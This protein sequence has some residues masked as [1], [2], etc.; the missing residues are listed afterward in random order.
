[1]ILIRV[2]LT[3]PYYEIYNISESGDLTISKY[4]NNLGD[5]LNSFKKIIICVSSSL[6]VVGSREVNDIEKLSK[7]KDKF[8]FG[9]KILD[10]ED[11][12]IFSSAKFK[13]NNIKQ[14][15]MSKKEFNNKINPIIE[16]YRKKIVSISSEI[17]LVDDNKNKSNVYFSEKNLN[18]IYKK[19]QN[20]ELKIY[21]KKNN[22]LDKF[23]IKENYN[24]L[25]L[26]TS[27]KNEP[28]FEILKPSRLK[29]FLIFIALLNIII[30]VIQFNVVKTTN[31][32]DLRKSDFSINEKQTFIEI[33]NKFSDYLKQQTPDDQLLT[34]RWIEKLSEDNVLNLKELNIDFDNKLIKINY[35]D[36]YNGFRDVLFNNAINFK[37][38]KNNDLIEYHINFSEID[39]FQ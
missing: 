37:E 16:N 20:R 17:F 12:L 25:K 22:L 38:I 28:K 30:F 18:H 9:N 8:F 33:S 39:K 27:Y 29:N 6:C 32:I 26:N 34:S 10:T 1:M 13:E 5:N 3:Q 11:N 7:I 14:I 2:K 36:N 4:L 21:S 35:K 15:W 31:F 19:D 23:L 24:G